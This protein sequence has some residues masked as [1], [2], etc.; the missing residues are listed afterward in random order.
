MPDFRRSLSVWLRH[1]TG[2]R[3]LP[4]ISATAPAPEAGPWRAASVKLGP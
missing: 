2:G 3:L 1:G 4:A